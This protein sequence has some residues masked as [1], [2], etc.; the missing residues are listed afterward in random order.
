MS[1]RAQVYLL[2]LL[3]ILMGLGLMTY[4]SEMLSMPVSP[5]EYATV[6]T[7]EAKVGFDAQGGA[8]KVSLAL[9]RNQNNMEVIEE[10]FSS[11]GYGFNIYDNAGHRR[12]E[13]TKRMASG[14]Q[15]L[16]YKLDVHK[17]PSGEGLPE[18][19]ANILRAKPNWQGERQ[20]ALRNAAAS[21]INNSWQSS[22]D[23]ESFTTQ[24]L[25]AMNDKNNN[26]ARLIHNKLLEKETV[27]LALDLLALAEIPAHI[28][29]GIYLED[30]RNRMSS[31]ALVEI[32]DGNKWLVFST[33]TGA[34]GL[35][36]NFLVWQRGDVSMIDV[37]GGSHS[38]VTFSVLANDVPARKV[39]LE[40]M[41]GEQA[42]LLDYSIYSL[43]IE[44]QSVFKFILLVPIGALMVIFLRVVIGIRTAGTFMPVLLAIAFIQTHLLNG[45]LI[46][47]LI[48]SIGLF[49]RSYL[50]RLDL[51][52]VAR[53]AA[54][55][56]IV[57]CLMSFISIVSFKLGVEQ[58]LTVTFFPM[59]II[60]WT[61]EHMS[62]LWEDD[63]P[64]EVLIQTAGSLAVAILCY[65][66][67]TN[68]YIEHWMFNFPELLFTL[69][70]MIIILGHYT[71]YR[72]SELIRFRYMRRS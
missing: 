45:V 17:R 13:W 55:V 3:L 70:G 41:G 36:D 11:S 65:L 51:L 22:A 25:K 30:D 54:V 48:L 58:A 63:G 34:K 18:L 33:K 38:A 59:I 56:V 50:S 68:H 16:Y 40:Q 21:I 9:P 61:I 32:Y 20:E 4:K 57:V 69:L 23:K 62:I 37:E 10:I 49:V 24:L 60:A 2:G 53:I 44:Q 28:I 72:A 26:D 66:A 67:M 35:P 39:A 19:D 46:F 15:T 47:L 5:G 6:W 7:V 42:A 1:P 8:V 31:D 71:G 64:M 43:P 29:R 52:L 12:A 27:D 14:K